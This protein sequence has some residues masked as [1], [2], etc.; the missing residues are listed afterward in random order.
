M[1]DRPAEPRGFGV[2]IVVMDRMLV[3]GE[4]SKGEDVCLGDL[5]GASRESL[6]LAEI[7]KKELCSL[8]LHSTSFLIYARLLRNKRLGF[9]P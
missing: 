3:T 2:F 1:D 7:F 4:C 8:L 5:S 9:P 6:T